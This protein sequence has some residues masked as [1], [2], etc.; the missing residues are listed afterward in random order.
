MNK[1]RSAIESRRDFMKTSVAAVA[2]LSCFPLGLN[3]VADAASLHEDKPNT[4]NMM[5]V[6]TQTAFLSHLPMLRR[7]VM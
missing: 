1:P 3:T 7:L 4:H 5:L 2:G 6:G